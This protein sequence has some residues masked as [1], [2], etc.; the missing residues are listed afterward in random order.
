MLFLCQCNLHILTEVTQLQG[1]NN[2]PKVL[3]LKKAN[4][5]LKK[6]K[7]DNTM[8]GIHFP[9]LT[10]PFCL[11]AIGD[12]NHTTKTSV[13]PQEGQFVL[14]MMD[15]NLSV[16]KGILSR[17]CLDSLGGPCHVLAAASNKAKKVAHSTSMGETNCALSVVGNAQMIALRLTELSLD[18]SRHR[19]SDNIRH[20]MDINHNGAYLIPI[21][22]LTDCK[23]AFE[24]I[25]GLKGIPQDKQQ[26]LPVMALRE[27]RMTGRVRLSLHI[28]TEIMI[29]DALTKAGTF[30][31]LMKLLTT[32]KLD[33]TAAK[34]DITVRRLRVPDCYTETDLEHIERFDELMNATTTP[35][36]EQYTV[37]DC[38][39]TPISTTDDWYDSS[40]WQC[41][42]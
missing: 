36:H 24:L 34:K 41:A 32:G 26:R 37:F 6:A 9:R 31:Q 5:V 11:R 27:E 7:T 23:D 3:H 16:S 8:V 10:P 21:D 12:A 13:Y 1:F 28:P 25:T 35:A 4:A 20:M 38:D 18:L 22:H 40:Y 39:D 30:V 15:R 33:L 19:H 17:S 2:E 14:L 42:D 29:S